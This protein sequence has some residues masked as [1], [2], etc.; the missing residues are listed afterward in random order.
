MSGF[1]PVPLPACEPNF[2]PDL[3]ATE[4]EAWISAEPVRA[5]VGRFGGTLPTTDLGGLLTWLDDFSGEHWDFRKKTAGVERDQV[6]A[7]EFDAPTARLVTDAATALQLV[8]P[9]MP[10][11]RNYDHLLVL[12]GLGRACLQRTEYAAHLISQGVVA[13]PEVAALGSFRPLTAAER[14]LPGLPDSGYEVDAMDVG[15]RGAF[16]LAEPGLLESS[17]DPVDHS[18]W[19]VR[20]YQ[21]PTGVRA[22]VLAA[23]SSDPANRRANTPDTYEFWAQRVKLRAVDRILVV[24][25]PIYVPFQHADA[26]RMLALRYGCGID[27]VGF[28]P[29]RVSVPLAPGATNPDRYLQEIR[30]GI[31]S[32]MRLYRAIAD[33]VAVR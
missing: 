21:S 10:P 4:I 29:G 26:L 14:E 1:A 22:H 15:L 8:E 2:Q 7:P 33:P 24:T 5:L 25:S 12:G 9:R 32:M 31:L 13:V 17:D 23:P 20:T 28:D 27:T 6:R 30:S 16:H 18:S 3:V 11:H 19:S